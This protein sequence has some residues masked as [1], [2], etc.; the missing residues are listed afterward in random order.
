MRYVHVSFAASVGFVIIRCVPHA[1]ELLASHPDEF[2]RGSLTTDPPAAM[3]YS[4]IGTT[5]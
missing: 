1:D 5:P 4:E 3:S 2:I